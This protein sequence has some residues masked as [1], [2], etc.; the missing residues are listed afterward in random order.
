FSLT[1]VRVLYELAHRKTVTAVELRDELG[2][3]RGYLSRLLQGFQTRGWVKATPSRIDRR[4]MFLSLTAKGRKVFAPLDRRSSDEV[5]AM[6]AQ[7]SPLERQS[8]LGAMR[9]I[10]GILGDRKEVSREGITQGV[11]LRSHRPGDMGWVVQ[12]HGELYWQEYRYD[13]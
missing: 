9:G 13:E 1:E 10:E 5:G 11:T 7:L 4:R 8:L 12:R 2:L 6:L 3:D